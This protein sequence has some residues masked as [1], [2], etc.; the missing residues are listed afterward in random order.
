MMVCSDQ[1]TFLGK[2]RNVSQRILFE[3]TLKKDD[4]DDLTI[5]KCML[6]GMPHRI[7]RLRLSLR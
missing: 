4:F 6:A 2:R 3:I 7:S 1:S 5:K